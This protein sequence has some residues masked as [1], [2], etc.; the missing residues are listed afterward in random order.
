MIDFSKIRRLTSEHNT[1]RRFGSVEYIAIHYTAGFEDGPGKARD[2]AEFYAQTEIAASADFFV[3]R[4]GIVQYNPAPERRYC[5]AVGGTSKPDKSQG[6]GSLW[7]KAR[8]SNTV[9]IE[10][11]SRY[12]EPVDLNNLPLPND[13]HYKLAPETVQMGAELAAYLLAEFMLPAD[14]LIRHFDVTGK[15]CP[16][17]VGWNEASGSVRK[18][19]EFQAAV[20]R[21]P[22]EPVERFNAVYQLPDWARPTITRLC[23]SGAIQGN[24]G[25]KD[26]NGR[27][28]DMDLSMDMIRTL[29]IYDRDRKGVS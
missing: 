3:D 24:G 14:R 11:C 21:I 18:W 20:W 7:N 25:T 8:N 15:L 29:V 23:D 27:P 2:N 28:A 10:L 26:V 9:S 13:P 17:V 5:W 4:G 12:D 16:G 19:Q 1:S 6:G 22:H